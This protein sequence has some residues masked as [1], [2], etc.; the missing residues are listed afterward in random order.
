[1][2]IMRGRFKPGDTVTIKGQ[3]F[4]WVVEGMRL[5]VAIANRRTR[6]RPAAGMVVKL[7]RDA[8]WAKIRYE[9]HESQLS[10]YTITGGGHA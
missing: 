6:E 2:N 7:I 5:R 9:A 4:I 1:M 10:A 8:G 3:P